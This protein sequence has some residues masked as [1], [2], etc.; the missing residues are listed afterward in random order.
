MTQSPEIAFH[1]DRMTCA[2]C[3][4]RAETALARVDGVASV[5]VNL[6]QARA[7]VQGAVPVGSLQSALAK[8]GYPMRVVTVELDLDNITCASCVARAETALTAL[9]HVLRASVNMTTARA[10]IDMP[11]GMHD[12]ASLIAA[13]AA[14]G[15]PARLRA[16]DS[17][18]PA[19][20]AAREARAQARA[21]VTALV[22]TLPVFVT[23]MGGH[24]IPAFHHWLHDLVGMQA[25][26]VGQFILTTL[27]LAGPGRSFY[28]RGLPA[29]WRGAPDMNSLVALGTLAAYVYSVIATFAP[30]ALPDTAR[31]VYFEAA[32]VIVTLILLGRWLE[33]RAKGRTGAAIA[34]LAG[35]QPQV[36]HRI[37]PDGQGVD[38]AISDLA[39]GDHVLV[40]PGARLPADGRVFDT[41]ALLDESMITGEP[42]P[43]LR[44]PEAKVTGGTVNAGD[45]AFVM[46][47]AATGA[48]TVLSQI[49]RMVELAQ[50][51]KLPVQALVDRVTLVFVPVVLGLAALTVA[52]W[53]VFGP[54]LS[55]A[56]VAGVSVLIIACPCAMGLAT[57]TSIVVGTGRAAELGVLFRKG[58][59]LQHLAG[60]RVV[61]FDKTGTL[62]T[63]K[64][65]LTAVHCAQGITRD[66]ALA[67]AAGLE[68]ASD[69]P[70]ARA[71][72]Q[73][74]QGLPLPEVT[75]IK[76]VTG[77]GL[78]G[79]VGGVSVAIGSAR[80]MAENGVGLD[81]FATQ[82]EQA[83]S[84]GASV[85]YLSCDGQ[86]LAMFAFSDRAKPDAAETLRSL[87]AQGLHIALITGDGRAP[88][89]ALAQELGIE[90]VHAEILPKAK[91]QIVADLRA[92]F[93]PV[94]FVGDGINDAPALA[95]ADVG[96]ALGTGTDVAIESADIV[97]TAGNVGGVV[98]ARILAQAT[99]RNIRQNLF[100]AFAYNAA[101][102]PVAAGLLYPLA[103]V[104]LSPMLAAGAMALSSVFVLS[105]ALR[106]RFVS[107]KP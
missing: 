93:G 8:A 76:T 65:I 24:L 21:F 19:T 5:A 97:L 96:I 73:A 106:L 38:V 63:G 101:L 26:W 49:I 72:V 18:D 74:A 15:Y 81:S 34:K 12:N 104:M 59:A 105:N 9:P 13:L 60:V 94:A 79:Q 70:L 37:G 91:A 44:A 25:L 39:V 22:L 41:P 64:P 92:H 103:G 83:A 54:S 55:F 30:G 33:V 90:T 50:G 11:D 3:V 67:L 27:V 95:A 89:D 45:S 1:L 53:L 62:T 82:G 68:R 10:Q 32:A 29:L 42:L 85:I 23:E 28:A 78:R 35:L 75:G 87:R 14:V 2:G 57:P 31:A 51:A 102:I 88:A 98:T 66:E 6:T 100:W 17:P 86:A 52:I 43:A 77:H 69:H 56:L 61:A 4:R 58:A 7:T 46:Q 99:M 84:D 20:R 16:S 80:F 36:A 48:Q 71:L 40:R 47:V 107:V